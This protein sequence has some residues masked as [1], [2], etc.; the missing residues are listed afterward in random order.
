MSNNSAI[1]D[2]EKRI[3]HYYEAHSAKRVAMATLLVGV[4]SIGLCW[5]AY[6]FTLNVLIATGVFAVGSLLA[7]NLVIYA[8]VPPTKQLT[9]SKERILGALNNPIQIKSVKNNK[10]VIAN[11]H[12]EV[13]S[14]SRLEQ[15]VWNSIVVPHFIKMSAGSGST[16]TPETL[17]NTEE[18]VMKKRQAEMIASKKELLAERKQLDE[19]RA[20][21]D[22]RAID[23]K[24]MQ[25]QLEDRVS[26]VEASE[27]DLARL[28]ANLQRRMQESENAEVDSEELALL[29]EKAAELKAKELALEATKQE[30][31][32]DRDQLEAKKQQLAGIRED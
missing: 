5:A 17:S 26:R 31:A 9:A 7:V 25:D 18:I 28:K 15:E 6:Y 27:A 19:V 21:L 3:D 22:V 32:G 29:H 12:G 20:A 10:V 8:I 30:L 23:L 16:S 24:K 2:L 13:Q 4:V 1:V 14:L 11:S